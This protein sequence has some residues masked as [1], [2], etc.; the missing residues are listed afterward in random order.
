MAAAT[1]YVRDRGLVHQDTPNWWYEI[2]FGPS[3]R[4]KLK[5]KGKKISG[6][7]V[8]RQRRVLKEQELSVLIPWLPNFSQAVNDALVLYL[9]T[10][11][12][13]A[14]IVRIESKEDCKEQDG[15]LWWNC[16]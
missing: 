7:H 13:G 16:P 8:G 3:L 5:S 15:I 9:W 1:S 2:K 12:R 10:G 11:V 14:E 4:K 6:V